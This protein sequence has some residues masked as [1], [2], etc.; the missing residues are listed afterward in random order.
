MTDKWIN[1][2]FALL[3]V[4]GM[5][6]EVTQ[7][8]RDA[9]EAQSAAATT[10][11]AIMDDIFPADEEKMRNTLDLKS[12]MGEVLK[13]FAYPMH[14]EV[15]KN[16]DPQKIADAAVKQIGDDH[17]RKLQ[18]TIT[19]IHAVAKHL[20]HID[21]ASYDAEELFV[22]VQPS[23]TYW[24]VEVTYAGFTHTTKSPTLT[25]ALEITLS[26][27]MSKVSHRIDEGTRLVAAITPDSNSRRGTRDAITEAVMKVANVADATFTESVGA[28]AIHVTPMRVLLI[29]EAMQLGVDLRA[30]L[31]THVAFPVIIK[32]TIGPV[33]SA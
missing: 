10:R 17:V 2:P 32:V 24:R 6:A 14:D 27:L 12:P 30:A 9:F 20:F 23:G 1:D 11:K 8:T 3:D 29:D 26:K 5:G 28:I 19:N 13:E 21:D 22:G 31:A 7:A 16:D 25:E 15:K 18:R 4:E 33:R